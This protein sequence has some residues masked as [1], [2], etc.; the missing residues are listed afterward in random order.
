MMAGISTTPEQRTA[1]AMGQILGVIGTNMGFT[2]RGN[3]KEYLDIIRAEL[4]IDL[5]VLEMR[6]V[7]FYAKYPFDV[8]LGYSVKEVKRFHPDYERAPIYDQGGIGDYDNE[9]EDRE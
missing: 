7:E 9:D 3:D 4:T 5:R 2:E 8:Y 6:L 1:H